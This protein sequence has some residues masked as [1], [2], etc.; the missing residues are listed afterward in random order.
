MST[1]SKKKKKSGK[2]GGHKRTKHGLGFLGVTN[3][4]VN[5]IAEEAKAPLGILAGLFV[6]KAVDSMLLSK[7]KFLNPDPDP[8]T[9]E[10][11]KGKKLLKPLTVVA[12]GIGTMYFTRKQSNPIIKGIGLG[13]VVYGGGKTVSVLLNKDLFG[14]EGAT[15]SGL[16]NDNPALSDKMFL[17]NKEELLKQIA[18]NSYTPELPSLDTPMNGADDVFGTKMQ[19]FANDD[20]L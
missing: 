13:M 6:A 8:A 12:L 9:G 5:A 4:K 14:F 20:V 2:K 3:S 7:V 19:V 15:L 17:E 11:S 16:G 10:V 1:K 18:A